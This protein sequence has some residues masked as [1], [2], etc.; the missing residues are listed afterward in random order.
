MTNSSFRTAICSGI[1]TSFLANLANRLD[2]TWA[3]YDIFAWVTAEFFLVVVCGCLPTL[4]PLLEFVRNH[5][6]ALASNT[7]QYGTNLSVISTRSGRRTEKSFACQSESAAESASELNSIAANGFRN[8]NNG[9][10][11]T[12][13]DAN[14]IDGSDSRVSHESIARIQSICLTD[15]NLQKIRVDRS[16]NIQGG[17]RTE[18]EPS[19]HHTEELHRADTMI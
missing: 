7:K 1:K 3:T 11:R 13:V 17:Y 10:T 12:F 9:Q 8:K 16:F 4:R 2:L 15:D 18:S 14:A 19:L 5:V 6:G